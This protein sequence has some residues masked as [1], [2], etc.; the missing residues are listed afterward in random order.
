MPARERAAIKAELTP[1]FQISEPDRATSPVVFCSPHS[2]RIY[3]DYFLEQSRLDPLTL[4]KSEDCYVDL[5]FDCAPS[6]GAPLI[7]ALFPRAYLDLNREAYELDPCLFG[8]KLPDYANTQTTRVIGG[9]GTIARIVGDGTDIYEG[10]LS[11][12]AGLERIEA[13]YH[14]FHNSLRQLLERTRATFGHALLIDCHSMPSNSMSTTTSRNRPDIVLGDR[15]GTSCDR[16]VTGFLQ[17]TFEGLGYLVH[18]NRPYAGGFITEHYGRP[19]HRVE[20]LQIE[21]NRGLYLNEHTLEPKPG[22]ERL[23]RDIETVVSQLTGTLPD[24]LQRPAA[25]E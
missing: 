3:P 20:A 17:R 8:N 18:I 19:T 16:I 13:L 23:R 21:I 1:A 9:L 24:F 14:P 11:L 15:F 2:G 6:Y 25:A 12:E 5:L 7:A 22:F 4:R 10:Q